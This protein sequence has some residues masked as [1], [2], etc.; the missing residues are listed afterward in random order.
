MG[1]FL[2]ASILLLIIHIGTVFAVPSSQ[3]FNLTSLSISSG[4]GISNSP[5]YKNYISGGII[6]GITN[7][8]LY[9]NL[10]GF[11][12]TWLLA[13]DQYCTADNQCESGI[14]SNNVCS[15]TRIV[16]T[17]ST[18]STTGGGGGAAAPSGGGGGAGFLFP[19]EDFSVSATTIT[20]KLAL[21]DEEVYLITLKNTGRTNLTIP[22]QLE[23]LSKYITIPKKEI[24]LEINDETSIEIGIIAKDVGSFIGQLFMGPSNLQKT[25]PIILEFISDLVLFDVKMDITREF[26]EVEAGSDLKTQITLLNV[27]APEKV[28]VF[29]TYFIKDLRGN[30]IYEETETFAVLEQISYQKNLPLHESMLPGNYVA[31]AEVKYADSFAVSSQLFRVVE[32]RAK[33]VKEL[34]TKNISLLTLISIVIVISISF[35]SYKLYSKKRKRKLKNF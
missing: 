35:L 1:K 3:N 10:V 22:I 24:F 15:A 27:G 18:T 33:I 21:G 25:I 31:I 20:T 12:Y 26:S 23:S 34:F 6:S 5:S 9:R 19:K 8:T 14:C 11:F 29:V 4:G 32:P 28:D 7:S 30:I 2:T 17:T 16:T 13:N